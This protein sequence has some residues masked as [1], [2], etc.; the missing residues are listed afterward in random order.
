M[1]CWVPPPPQFISSFGGSVL[2]IV[3]H[4]VAPIT[5][6]F[7][8]LYHLFYLPVQTLLCYLKNIYQLLWDPYVMQQS[9]GVCRVLGLI[10]LMLDMLFG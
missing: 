2:G 6:D 10:A 5:L 4:I 7:S 9:I 1:E 8:C 3:A